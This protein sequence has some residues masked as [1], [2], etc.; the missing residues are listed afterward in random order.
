MWER[1]HASGKWQIEWLPVLFPLAIAEGHIFISSQ[2]IFVTA[3]Y[4]RKL[5]KDI[6]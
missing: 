3:S 4:A 1:H 5:V 6:W 2:A